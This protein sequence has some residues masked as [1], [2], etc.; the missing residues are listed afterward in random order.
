MSISPAE[1]SGTGMEQHTGEVR[2]VK[3]VRIRDERAHGRSSDLLEAIVP[4][5]QKILIH[6]QPGLNTY[7]V[8][9]NHRHIFAPDAVLQPRHLPPNMHVGRAPEMDG[10]DIYTA[11]TA[12]CSPNMVA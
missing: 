6:R 8:S 5:S 11:G 3:S 7:T 4:I 2:A 9:C 1:R 12:C 10:T